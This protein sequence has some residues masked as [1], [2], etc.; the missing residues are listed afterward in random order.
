M[1][2]TTNRIEKRNTARLTGT[3]TNRYR[4][5]ILSKLYKQLI[6]EIVILTDGNMEDF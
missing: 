6:R 1:N 5:L 2:V 3:L 4:C